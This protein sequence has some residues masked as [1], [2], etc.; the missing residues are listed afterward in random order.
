MLDTAIYARRYLANMATTPQQPTP[1]QKLLQASTALALPDAS[2]IALVRAGVAPDAIYAALWPRSEA[3]APLPYDSFLS[4][5]R[6]LEI[7][8]AVTTPSED[9]PREVEAVVDDL[10]IARRQIML[11]LDGGSLTEEGHF[12]A[13]PHMALVKNADM[14]LKLHSARQ[15]RQI[16]K[17]NLRVAQEKAR[18]ELLKLYDDAN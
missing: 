5:V 18:L 13:G 9:L 16:H 17:L 12:D 2:I 7:A 8:E 4:V 15:D 10:L 1:P 11:A 14:V 6:A 3:P